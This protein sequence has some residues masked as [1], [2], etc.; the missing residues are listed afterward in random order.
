VLKECGEVDITSHVDFGRLKEIAEAEN[1]S[2]KL[3]GQGDFLKRLG[4]EVRA[5][6]LAQKS[7]NIE[8]GLRRLIDED[9]MGTLFRVMEIK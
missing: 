5:E 7:E 6:Q 8:A 4:V 2:V 3:S 1:L 9:A